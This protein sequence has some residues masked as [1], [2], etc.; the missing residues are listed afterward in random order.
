MRSYQ[1]E[2]RLFYRHFAGTSESYLFDMQGGANGIVDL[3]GNALAEPLPQVEFTIDS[4]EATRDTSGL[5]LSFDSPALDE[6][7]SGLPKIMGQLLFDPTGGIKPRAV[8]HFSKVADANQIALSALVATQIGIQTPFSAQG[9]R[10]Q[11]VWRY[12]DLGLSTLNVGDFDLDVEGLHY[13]PWND[14][15]QNDTFP[16]FQMFLGHSK[17]LPDDDLNAGLPNFPQSGLK[18]TFQD[19]YADLVAEPPTVVGAKQ[20][21]FT[22]SPLNLKSTS[23]GMIIHPLPM[24]FNKPVTQYT[25]WTWRDTTKSFV[26]GANS[27]GYDVKRYLFL[28]GVGIPDLYPQS[29]VPTLGLPMLIEFRAYPNATT[30]AQNQFR[31]AFG[32]TSILPIF[33][34]WVSGSF[35]GNPFNPDLATN[36]TGGGTGSGLPGLDNTFYYGQADFV[37]RISRA[38]TLFFDTGSA[39]LFADPV[40]EPDLGSQPANTQIVLAYRGASSITPAIVGQTPWEDSTKYNPYGDSWTFTLFGALGSQCHCLFVPPQV[41]GTC[42]VTPT[43]VPNCGFTP[44]FVNGANWKE[45]ISQIGNSRYVQTRL[46]LVSNTQ[47]G[48][49]PALSGLG[50]AFIK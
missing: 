47:T 11:T 36:A 38:F 20:D 22:L 37:V 5:V 28:G 6:D 31:T 32:P 12:C 3:A 46:T 7:G 40:L 17:Y 49:G 16:E 2:P 26:G 13:A 35:S 44:A 19:N 50:F 30:F 43:L 33:R 48:L 15:I 18:A 41:T 42:A 27:G 14:F 23:T 34:A 9:A 10:M 8:S 24:N 4:G 1:F 25:Y 39:N 21:G 29:K 45:Q